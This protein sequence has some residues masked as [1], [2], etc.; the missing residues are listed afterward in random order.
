MRE[1]VWR[2]IDTIADAIRSGADERAE[3]KLYE[4]YESS[5]L[6]VFKVVRHHPTDRG[7]DQIVVTH[8]W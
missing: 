6:I 7:R 2:R 1:K 8:I 5:F 4:A 3:E